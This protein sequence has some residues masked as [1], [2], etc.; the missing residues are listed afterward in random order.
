MAY[1]FSSPENQWMYSSINGY[2]KKVIHIIKYLSEQENNEQS[3]GKFF[4]DSEKNRYFI[5]FINFRSQFPKILQYMSYDLIVDIDESSGFP[6]YKLNM[7]HQACKKV[8]RKHN[9]DKLL[10]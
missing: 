7:K 10:D 4:E 1:P 9:L 3:F 6:H 2:D 5:N 8:I